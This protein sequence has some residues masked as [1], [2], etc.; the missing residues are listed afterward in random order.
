MISPSMSHLPDC[1]RQ[2]EELL[3]RRFADRIE[4][5]PHQQAL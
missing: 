4:G 3:A 2:K 5:V 1:V